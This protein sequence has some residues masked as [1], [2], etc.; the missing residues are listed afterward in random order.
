LQKTHCGHTYG[1]QCNHH[2]LLILAC[3]KKP[4]T[5]K[6]RGQSIKNSIFSPVPNSHTRM[7]SLSANNTSEKFSRWAPLMGGKIMTFISPVSLFFH[8]RTCLI[9][10]SCKDKN[11]KHF[12]SVF[13][14]TTIY[15][16][17]CAPYLA[18]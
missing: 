2:Q 14:K 11:R 8:L 15:A 16:L 6:I 17:D 13:L 7:G 4:K 5:I 10:N 3:G 18:W 12:M 9:D 1:L